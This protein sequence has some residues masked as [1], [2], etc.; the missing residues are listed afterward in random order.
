MAIVHPKATLNPSKLELLEVWLPRQE[1]ANDGEGLDLVGSYRFDDPAGEVGIEA[2]IVRSAEGLLHV[3]L[4]YRHA[5]L[6]G[7][8][9]HLV[10]TM[11]HSLL[12]ERF[13]YDGEF[14][15]VWQAEL[16]RVVATGGTEVEILTE[17]DGQVTGRR[18]ANVTVK[19]TGSF[20]EAPHHASIN[21]VRRIGEVVHGDAQ[22]LG[23]W[24]TGH[25]V[26][27]AVRFN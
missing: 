14:D 24:K 12:G 16:I 23:T 3:P 20:A 6:A 9:A 27:A 21:V 17:V 19:G 18:E 10:G 7:A 2:L 25:G 11:E 5:P 4:T 13:V 8:E 15:P 22:L 1:W 26:L